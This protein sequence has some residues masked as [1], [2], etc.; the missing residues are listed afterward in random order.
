[1]TPLE[2][3]ASRL[4]LGFTQG[5]MAQAVGICRSTLVGWERGHFP[6]PPWFALAVAAVA[7]GLPPYRPS[8]VATQRA[9]T[10]RRSHPR[11][12]PLANPVGLGGALPA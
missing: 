11:M 8:E 10:H 9:A 12:G 7:G 3:K 5:Q 6:A 2:V 1:M 4:D